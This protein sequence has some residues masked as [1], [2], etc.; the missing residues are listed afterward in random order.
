MDEPMERTGKPPMKWSDTQL[1]YFLQIR[2]RMIW[3]ETKS[4]FCS[5]RY[6][7]TT[8][9]PRSHWEGTKRDRIIDVL[10]RAYKYDEPEN[11]A[12]KIL[13]ELSLMNDQS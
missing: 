7:L 5:I 10:E 3:E 12:D 6:W 1:H 2:L 13:I 8:K 11:L 4:Y 9:G